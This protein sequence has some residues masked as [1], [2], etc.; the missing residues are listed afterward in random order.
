H[1]TPSHAQVSVKYVSGDAVPVAPPTSRQRPAVHARLAPTRAGGLIAGVRSV[2]VMPS[3]SQVS[4]RFAPDG[5]M[6]PNSTTRR[7][8]GSKLIENRIL[9][10]G[11][12]TG[13]RRSHETP[14]QCQV[15]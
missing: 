9:R 6:P 5:P 10:D 1:V 8:P 2:H 12:V 13:W 11:L 4:S 7:R 3:H 15:S 14:S